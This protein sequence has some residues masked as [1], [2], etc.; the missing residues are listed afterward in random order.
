MLSMQYSADDGLSGTVLIYKRA[1]VTNTEYTLF[2]NGLNTAAEYE[3]YDID[4]PDKVYTMKGVELMNYG[5]TLPLPEGEKAII[6]M[7][8]AK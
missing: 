7:F 6:I 1:E 5:L 8:T 3:L 2:L 4:N